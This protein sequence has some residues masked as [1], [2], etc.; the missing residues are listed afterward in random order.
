MRTKSR[1]TASAI[2]SAALVGATVIAG[3]PAAQAIPVNSH[4]GTET[5]GPR[6]SFV[7]HE[8]LTKELERIESTSK[9][10]VEV[11]VAG[12]SNQGREIYQARVGT[13]DTVVL[14]QSQI[15]GNENHGTEALLS[16]LKE[17]GGNS[18]EAAAIR[19][20]VTIVAIPR[21]NVDGGE[22]DTRQNHMTWDDVVADFPQLAGVQPAWNYRSAT[23]GFDVNRD[24][25]PDLDYVPAPE[26]FPGNSARTGWYIT[27][28]AQ[29]LRDVYAGL[30]DEFGVVDYFVDLHNQWP[31]YSQVGT[32]NMSTLSIS[33]RFI[34]D[35]TQFGDWPNFD[36][37]ASRRAN[38]AVYDALQE[39]GDSAFG[40]LTLY[41]QDTNLPGTALGS[42][43][44]RGSATV[45]FETSSNTQ[46]D[47]QKRNGFLTKQVETGLK[48]L[49]TAVADGSVE[50]LDPE[51]YEE[52]PERIFQPAD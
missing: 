33:G 1:I 48:G 7:S 34:A 32:D 47:G 16:L 27:P 42:F 44:L 19:D 20:N 49:I 25:N 31:C 51:A 17:F 14:V 43:A 35:P 26:D 52:I 45:L 12:Y 40:H 38:V 4:C 9:G 46:S 8:Q 30:E 18:A 39:R 10:L 23:P 50:S 28:E 29:T 3:V 6:S 5:A 11:D 22:R 15:H 13:G 2:A 41:P 21:L 37:D 36:Y 24:F